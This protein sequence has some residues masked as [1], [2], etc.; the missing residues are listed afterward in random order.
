[1][2]LFC[3]ICKE[4]VA[5]I[6]VPTLVSEDGVRRTQ[7]LS[8][9]PCNCFHCCVHPQ[10][11]VRIFIAVPFCHLL[12]GLCTLSCLQPQFDIY[13]SFRLISSVSFSVFVL[14]CLNCSAVAVALGF[15]C[16][17]YMHTCKEVLQESTGQHFAVDLAHYMQVPICFISVYHL[18]TRCHVVIISSSF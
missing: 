3:I 12:A 14:T 8:V 5:T 2:Y 16:R 7:C 4:I 9:C 6:K 10:T 11:S 18:Q 17:R 13:V 1:M 15:V